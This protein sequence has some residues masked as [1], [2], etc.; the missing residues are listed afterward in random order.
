VV[1]QAVLDG[2]LVVVRLLVSHG[3][4][5]NKARLTINTLQLYI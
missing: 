4:D 5:I 3:A 1:V 2:N